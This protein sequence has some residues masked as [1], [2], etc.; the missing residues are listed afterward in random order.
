MSSKMRLMKK[1]MTSDQTAANMSEN[2]MQKSEDQNSCNN[3]FNNSNNTIRV[4]ADCNTTKTPL[5]RSGPRGPKVTFFL[6]WKPYI[7]YTWFKFNSWLISYIF[8]ITL[9]CS[10]FAT[11]VELGRGR[12]GEPWLLLQQLQMARFL[13][14]THQPWRLLRWNTKKRKPV[15]VIFH[16]RKGATLQHKLAAGKSFVLRTWR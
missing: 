16:S 4:C 15:I 8:T 6:P 1:M 3:S 5:W 14:L 9:W 10:H 7:I 11:L 2:S 13:L 12:Q